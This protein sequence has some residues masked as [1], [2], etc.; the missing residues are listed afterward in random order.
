LDGLLYLNLTY[1]LRSKNGQSKGLWNQKM[2]HKAEIRA[3]G[4]YHRLGT[5]IDLTLITQ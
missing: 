4:L 1:N 3:H 5:S 2:S